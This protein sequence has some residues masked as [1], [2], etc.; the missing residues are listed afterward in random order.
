MKSQGATIYKTHAKTCL[1]AKI[2]SRLLIALFGGQSRTPAR[3]VFI[4]D[5]AIH[6]L[7]PNIM[8]E[9]KV[10]KQDEFFFRIIVEKESEYY[11]LEGLMSL[12]RK[13]PATIQT[14]AV[15]VNDPF[16]KVY[17]MTNNHSDY[18]GIESRL[19]VKAEII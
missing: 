11:G 9:V 1:E 10:L 15:K 16:C 14:I 12:T 4:R 3:K 8:S 2:L 19:N 13:L 18:M 17:C 6:T 5:L 7:K